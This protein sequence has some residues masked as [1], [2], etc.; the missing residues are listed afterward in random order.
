LTEF[1][2]HSIPVACCLCG[3]TMKYRP[4]E[5]TLGVPHNATGTEGK[6][7]TENS[8]KTKGRILL[9]AVRPRE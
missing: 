8:R 4:S 6:P 1:P 5:L 7:P 9:F 2:F 3:K